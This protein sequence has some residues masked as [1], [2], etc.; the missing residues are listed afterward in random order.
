MLEIKTVRIMIEKSLF[1]CIYW[2][3]KKQFNVHKDYND[4]STYW[5]GNDL[6]RI[7]VCFFDWNNRN[8]EECISKICL[9][10][11][12]KSHFIC[13]STIEQCTELLFFMS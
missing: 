6:Y 4:V 10:F 11:N 8:K 12:V 2:G 1:R 9:F 3:K 13:L 7:I 5:I